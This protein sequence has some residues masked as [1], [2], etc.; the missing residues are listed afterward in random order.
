MALPTSNIVATPKLSSTVAFPNAVAAVA[1]ATP[2]TT[3]VPVAIYHAR[4][5]TAGEEPL[6]LVK[7]KDG[8]CAYIKESLLTQSG[9]IVSI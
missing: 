4:A 6:Y 5:V 2:S 1:L 7:M 3:Q 9:G 8:T